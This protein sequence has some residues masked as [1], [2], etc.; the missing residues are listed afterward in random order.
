MDPFYAFLTATF[1]YLEYSK[2]K[3]GVFALAQTKAFFKA[4]FLNFG[5][6]ILQIF[7][8]KATSA[9]ASVM[10]I[11]SR[12]EIIQPLFSQVLKTLLTV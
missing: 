4:P 7:S 12:P 6:R 2:I 5:Y 9:C 11:C 8:A 1:L 10:I 3:G